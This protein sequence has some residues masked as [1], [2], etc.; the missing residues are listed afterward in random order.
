MWG[1]RTIALV[2]LVVMITGVGAAQTSAAQDNAQQRLQD[3]LDIQAL[4]VRYGTALDTLDADAYAGVFTTDAELDVAGNVRKGRQ[5]IREIVTSLQ[6]S[7]DENK[8]KGTPSPVLY[9]VISN[10]AIEILNND[11]ARHRSYWQT[12]RVGPNNQVTVGAIGQYEDVIVKRAGQWLIRSRKITPFT[13]GITAP[14][15]Q[16]A[17][18][19]PADASPAVRLQRLEDM[20]EIRTLLL[21]YG[22]FLDSRDLVAYSRLFAKDGEWVG[23]FGSARG[24]EEILAFMQ[25]NLG[26]GPNRGNTYHI[27]SNFEI[28]TDRDSATA[29]SRWTFITPGADGKPV[30]S[31]AG[32][33][34]DVLVREDGRWRFKRRVASNDIPAPR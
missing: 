16:A 24:P 22:R 11:E 18:P 19:A 27:L 32:R 28:A 33:Y 10:T 30:I 12:V 17:R 1:F 8:A 34:D 4:I 23:G 31:Q 7:R 13:D 25:K 26:T 9:H 21:D 3:K 6:R 15:A 20:E 2:L 29:W 5:Q 14:A